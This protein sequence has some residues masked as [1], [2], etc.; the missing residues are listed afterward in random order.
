M[1]L[2]TGNS[3]RLS[4]DASAKARKKGLTFIEVMVTIVILTS[5]LVAI[6]RAFFIGVNYVERLSHRLYALNLL[7]SKIAVIEKDFRSLKD[8]NIGAMTESAVIDHHTVDF[9]Y[10]IHMA[11]VGKLLSVFA[12]D[13]TLTWQE[14]GQIMS[15]SRSAYFSGITSLSGERGS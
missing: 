3:A 4:W 5:G 10:T 2:I 8:F 1:T 15:I 6:Y 9:Q 11:P 13:I 12:L 14:R 7:D